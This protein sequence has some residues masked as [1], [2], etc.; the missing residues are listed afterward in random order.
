MSAAP[1]DDVRARIREYILAEYLPDEDPAEL[2]YDTP[3]LTGGI[4]DSISIFQLLG[5]ILQ[6]WGVKLEANEVANNMN[7]VEEIA[8]IVRLKRDA[9]G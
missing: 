8:E 9:P 1:T 3:L 5:F 6:E 2:T 4:L 7:T